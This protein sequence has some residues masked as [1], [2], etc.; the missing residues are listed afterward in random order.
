MNPEWEAA[1]DSIEERVRA[2]EEAIAH[3]GRIAAIGEMPTVETPLPSY[4]ALRAMA[5]LER[6]RAV[7]TQVADHL[8]RLRAL[9]HNS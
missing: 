5:L 6:S 7:E 8:H 9:R 3:F 2:Q 4:L 1:L